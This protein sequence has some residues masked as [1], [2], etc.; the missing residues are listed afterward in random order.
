ML[1]TSYNFV[2]FILACFV[3]Y[4][5]IPKKF[6][7]VLL[8]AASYVFYFMAGAFYPLFILA[9]SIITYFTAI[10]IADRTAKDGEYLK[11]HRAE[12]SREEKKAYRVR[13]NRV[14]KGYMLLGLLLCLGILAVFK[15]ADFAV[16]NINALF[17]AFGSEREL[18]YLDLLLPMGISF[19]T[20]QSIGYLL[21]VYWEKT[22]AQRN[23][24]KYMLF[25]SF[26]PQLIQG[27][28]SRYSDLSKTL[29]EEHSFDWRNVRFGLERVLWG[30]FKKLVVADTILA[31]VSV[32]ISDEYYS[33]AWVL[34]GII[35]YGI[36]LY[37]DFTG[38]I[39]ITIG[40]AQVFGV[41]VQENFIRPYF[42]K[43]I[44]EYWRRWHIS[45]GTWFRD[46]IFYPMSIS[47][48][49]N[50][51]TKV[52][53][54]RFG[55]GVAKRVPVYLATMVTWFATGVWHGA[56]WNFIVWGLL[57]GVIILITGELEPLY[58]RFR[59]KFPRLTTSVGYKGFQILRT[60]FLM[61][62]L[63]MLDCYQDVEMTFRMFISMFRDFDPAVLTL[64]E[65]AEFGLN[66]Q[67][68]LVVF[69]GTVI[70]FLVSLAGRNG[71]V[72]E[73]IA[74]KPYV[75]RYGLFVILFLSVIL[76]GSYGVGFD[77]TQFI[78]NQ[79]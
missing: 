8:L 44:V 40:V 49:M 73:K 75:V 72:R 33:G 20:F 7:W 24:P 34:L 11:T 6:Q 55:K 79:F 1:L 42:S 66:W 78:Y 64:E 10:W 14:K 57:N 47:K 15:Y 4:Y 67:Q 77:A 32:I 62:C 25:V 19:Y 43:N 61:G 50:N 21:D 3:L 51:L 27:P 71:S 12:L 38:G 58:V 70:M 69:A 9:T 65:F 2:I 36:E 35:F 48:S 46:Y 26:F 5:L 29:Y 53:K 52:C 59:E 23:L 37:A 41:K 22:E 68:Y 63:R 45:M 17:A 39:D 74:A 16:E 30:Y 76:F 56:S 31:A 13:S 60:F 54:N 28:I 18:E